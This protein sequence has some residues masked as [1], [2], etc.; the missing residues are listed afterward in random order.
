[1]DMAVVDLG[2]GRRA[3]PATSVTVFGPGRARRA[4][5]RRVGGLGGHHRAR[6]RHRP[7]RAGAS[8]RRDERTRVA[9]IGGG[10]NCEHE[11]S[12]ASAAAVARR[13]RPG[14]VRR[15]RADHR[16]RRRLARREGAADRARRRRPRAAHLRRRAPGRC[17]A[18]A[19][20]TARSRPLCELAGVPYVGSGVARRRAGHGQ[21]G[22]QAGRARRSA[23]PPPPDVL[24]TA[25]TAARTPWTHPVVVKPVA[26]GSSHGV[27]A[28]PRSPTSSARA[29]AAA[30]A[31]DDRVLVE[32]VVDGREIDVAVLGRPDGSRVVA[33]AARDRRRRASSTTPRSTTA[34]A[35]FR[36]PAAL[37][38]AERQG[39]RGR[40]ASRSTT[41]WAAPASP[42]STSS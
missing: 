20:R 11:V 21:V 32:D 12:L 24:L 39:A 10:Q 33:P 16:P 26:A 29:L 3:R 7:R 38:D 31:L 28:G 25:A 2:A 15:R 34:S 17:T 13:A 23:S 27:G 18:R 5:H 36:I 41:P 4:D 42:G 6:D 1:M 22:H 40:R 37:G 8:T 30:L 19:A 9:V 14:R 35:D